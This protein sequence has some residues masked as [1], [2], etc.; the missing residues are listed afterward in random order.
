M[1]QRQRY[2]HRSRVRK[3]LYSDS[4]DEV[5]GHKPRNAGGLEK[6]E[7]SRKWIL[8][9]NFQK[10]TQPCQHLNFSPVRQVSDF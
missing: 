8:P 7:K 2:D 4:E 10:G 3:T 9:K 5:R 6:Q 1:S